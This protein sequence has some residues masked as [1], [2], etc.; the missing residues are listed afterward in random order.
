MNCDYNRFVISFFHPINKRQVEETR[1]DLF[2]FHWSIKLSCS[3]FIGE[4]NAIGIPLLQ[5]L[6]LGVVVR[7]VERILGAWDIGTRINCTCHSLNST[8]C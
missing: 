6:W 3:F 5:K 2:K 4:N 1:L 7:P 8:T